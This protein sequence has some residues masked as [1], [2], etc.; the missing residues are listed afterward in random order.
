MLVVPPPISTL[1]IYATVVATHFQIFRPAPNT[2]LKRKDSEK[3]FPAEVA[4]IEHQHSLT[5]RGDVDFSSVQN[6][7]AGAA[8]NPIDE[9]VQT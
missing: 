4:Y 5:T 3:A 6:V 7:E 1:G 2:F 8:S 9:I